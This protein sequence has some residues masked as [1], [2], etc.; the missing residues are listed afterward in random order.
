MVN[1][2]RA[3]ASLIAAWRLMKALHAFLSP[4]MALV[5]RRPSMRRQVMLLYFPAANTPFMTDLTNVFR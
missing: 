2:R 3:A 4:A 1:R 5:V